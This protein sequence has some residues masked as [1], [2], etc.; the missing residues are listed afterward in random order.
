MIKQ[1]RKKSIFKWIEFLWQCLKKKIIKDLNVK[2]MDNRNKQ[3]IYQLLENIRIPLRI[4][5]WTSKK[6]LNFQVVR[7]PLE[8]LDKNFIKDSN[9]KWM[10]NRNK[11]EISKL[12][13][14]ITIL[15]I[16]FTMLEFLWII[17]QPTIRRSADFVI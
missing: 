15:W 4:L 16:Y 17:S 8:M 9:V 12:F 6:V 1:A 13:K 2:L 5:I 14:K 11:Q 3:E 7:I 10:D